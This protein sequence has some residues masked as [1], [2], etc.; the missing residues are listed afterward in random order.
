[1]E[2]L[3]QARVPKKGYL[4]NRNYYVKEN[5][6]LNSKGPMHSMNGLMPLTRTA[7]VHN[8]SEKKIYDVS[9]IICKRKNLS[10]FPMLI[11][12]MY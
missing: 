12:L 11:Y 9:C 5:M 8:E 2:L 7:Y 4:Y 1:M 6:K 10:R 3:T